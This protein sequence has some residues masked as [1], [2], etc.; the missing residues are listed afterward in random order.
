MALTYSWDFPAFDCYPTQDGYTDV[1]FTVHWRYNAADEDG[2]TAVVYSMQAVSYKEGDPFVPFADLTPEIV[3]G[4]V[5]AAM[6][7][8]QVAA[9][10]ANLAEQIEQQI[11]PSQVTLSPPWQT[12]A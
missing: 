7:P 3:T 4:W 2:H 9:L 5:E 6:G 8:E 1:V 10:Q 12:P 11:H